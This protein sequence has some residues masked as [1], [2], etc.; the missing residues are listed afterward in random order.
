M[1]RPVRPHLGPRHGRLPRDSDGQAPPLRVRRAE[2][3]HK[4]LRAVG[5]PPVA[6]VAQ[7]HAQLGQRQR[8]AQQH[9]QMMQSLDGRLRSAERPHCRA[10]R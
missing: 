8:L 6:L 3:E 5:H 1:Q 4:L 7:E 2:D 10:V 9:L